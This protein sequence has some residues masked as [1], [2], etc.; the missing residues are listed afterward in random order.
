MNDYSK[1]CQMLLNNGEL[2]GNK[3]IDRSS[4]DLMLEKH[5]VLEP[6]PF[7]D[8]NDGFHF[9]FSVFV[10]ND[11]TKDDTNSSKG[12]YGWSGYHNT[13]FSIDNEKNLFGLF[14]TR[15]R[16]FSFGIQSEF[17]KA[18]YENF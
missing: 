12:I 17:R 4:I 6:D 2:N 3:I 5:S 7:L 13:H 8:I 18:V 1:F 14:M 10:L 16:E 15:A 9:G 11:T